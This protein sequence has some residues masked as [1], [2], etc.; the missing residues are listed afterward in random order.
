MKINV[1][2]FPAGEINAVELHDALATC[3]NIELYGA[4]SIDRHGPYVFRNFI[5]GLPF[6]QEDGFL[7]AFNMILKEYHIDA[8]FPTHDTV[9]AYLT[10]HREEIGAKIIAADRETAKVCRDKQLTYDLFAG[11]GFCPTTYTEDLEY[12]V[13]VKPRQGQGSKGAKLVETP[14]DLPKDFTPRHYVANEYLPGEE[15]TVDCFTDRKGDLL[16][17]LPRVRGRLLAGISVA[18]T[19]CDPDTEMKHIAETLNQKLRFRGLWWFQVKRDRNGMAKLLEIS[20]RCAGSMCMARAKGVNLPLLSVYDAMGWDVTAMVNPYHVTMDRTL[21]SRYQMDY[22]YDTVYFD[23]DDTLVIRGKVHLPAIRFLYQCANKSKRIILI[24]KHEMDI[25]ADLERFRIAATLFDEIIALK[26][27][28]S[29]VSYIDPSGAILV[30]NAFAER[31]QVYDAYG[32]PVFD[33]DM[34]EVLL[35]WRI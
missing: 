16:V 27:E 26:P 34:I 12:P 7:D 21:I 13:F 5:S 6:L 3:V 8:V 14:E 19:E 1:L 17:V 4:S 25:Y 29:K 15:L 20:T 30:D 28:D 18:A 2:V 32:I 35:D 24:T 22:P 31:K 33:V 23:F 11:E 9:A 10:E